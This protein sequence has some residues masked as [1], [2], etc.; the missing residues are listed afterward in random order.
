MRMRLTP[1]HRHI[2]LRTLALACIFSLGCGSDGSDADRTG[3]AAECVATSDCETYELPDA[4]PAQLT[5]LTT[6]KG[7]YCGI[8]GCGSSADCPDGAICVRHT[9]AVNYCFR[10]CADKSECN[11]NR[12]AENEANCSANF[13]WATTTDDDGSKACIPPSGS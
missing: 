4:E 12:S 9:N 1:M 5:C 8:E 6:F 10:V 3:V 13:D 11:R 2:L 7:G